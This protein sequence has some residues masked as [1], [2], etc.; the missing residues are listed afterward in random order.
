MQVFTALGVGFYYGKNT[1]DSIIHSRDL[2]G[3]DSLVL[4]MS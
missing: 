2:R 3:D 1:G 4:L